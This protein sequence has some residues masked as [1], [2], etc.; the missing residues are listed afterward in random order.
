MGPLT[1]SKTL[2]KSSQDWVCPG[3]IA[4]SPAMLTWLAQPLVSQGTYEKTMW[5]LRDSLEAFETVTRLLQC[6]PLAPVRRTMPG[7]RY[8]FDGASVGVTP[9]G[10]VELMSMT[11]AYG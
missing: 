5:T 7:S 8:A 3:L 9:I 2:T 4:M 6:S 1:E 11:V 10:S